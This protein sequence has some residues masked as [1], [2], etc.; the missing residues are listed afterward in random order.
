MNF[1]I[2]ELTN[3]N[4]IE[5][6]RHF[7]SDGRS[8]ITISDITEQHRYEQSLRESENWIR[9]ITDNVPAMI[10]YVNKQKQFMFTNKVYNQWYGDPGQDL[11]G[12]DLEA[13]NLFDDW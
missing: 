6:R 1:H 5:V 9:T 10:A 8:I 13:S 4:V 2:Q 3:G 12:Q 11:I 7:I